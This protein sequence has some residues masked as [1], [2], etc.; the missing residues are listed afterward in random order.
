L[1][2]VDRIRLFKKFDCSSLFVYAVKHLDLDES[3]AYAAITVARKS[4][5]IPELLAS[6]RER[7]L[8]I[9]KANRIASCLIRE[10]ASELV[11][12]AETHSAS[13]INREVRDQ[14]TAKIE[15]SLL[16]LEKL[17]RVKALT[18][19]SLDESLSQALD[20]YLEKHD[21]VKKAERALKREES[22]PERA[23]K[24]KK[25]LCTYRVI[26]PNRRKPLTASEKHQVFA[27]DQGRCTHRDADGKRCTNE[28]YL[29]I[30]HIQPV[31][32]GGSNEPGNL[33]TL[34]SYHHDLVHQLSFG[35]EGQATWLREP[36]VA[37][38]A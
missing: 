9:S 24:T 16:T 25:S 36:P 27:R 26:R 4:V 32:Q 17:K 12:F 3:V 7:K 22:K 30:H 6:I 13:E 31:R 11:A 8:S 15:I 28:R 1:R 20:E 38:T 21:P 14:E 37:Y 10:N 35:I 5:E 29:Q 23:P 19:K 2:E 34:C 18:G 33:T